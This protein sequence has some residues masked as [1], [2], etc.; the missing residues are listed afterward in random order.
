ME[1]NQ[2][3][4]GDDLEEI[5]AIPDLSA[6]PR[7]HDLITKVKSKREENAEK[8]KLL[9]LAYKNLQ[10]KIKEVRDE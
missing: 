8:L 1:G 6:L 10:D 7:L 5:E 3:I 9:D 2:I 4:L